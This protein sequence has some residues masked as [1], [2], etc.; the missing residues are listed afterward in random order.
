MSIGVSALVRQ[1]GVSCI[2]DPT[3]G[4]NARHPAIAQEYG[5][6]PIK[7]SAVTSP[8]NLFFGRFDLAQLQRAYKPDLFPLGV[9]SVFGSDAIGRQAMR[10]TPS[11]FSGSV[12][13]TLDVYLAHNNEVPPDGEAQ[14]FALEDAM[15]QAFNSEENYQLVPGGVAYNN[16]IKADQGKMDYDG[17]RWIQLVSFAMMFNRVA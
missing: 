1:F 14:F 15:V 6:E 16:E 12:V 9:L 17:T 8:A 7:F 3:L 2:T 11:T 4:F 5:V 10:V 13:L